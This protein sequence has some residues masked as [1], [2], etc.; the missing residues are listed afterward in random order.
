MDKNTVETLVKAAREAR[1]NAY[2]PYSRFKVGAALLGTD[3]K[4]YRGC[5]V[6]NGSY[7]LTSCAERNAVFNAIAAGCRTF[8]AVALAGAA[9]YTVPCGACRQVLAEFRVPVVILTKEN[10]TYT[11]AALDSLLPQPFSL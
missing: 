6:E 11:C 10:G 8:R 4:I 5:N 1:E 3:G 2:A 9:D 7:G